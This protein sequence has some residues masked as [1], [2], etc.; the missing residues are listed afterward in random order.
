MSENNLIAQIKKYKHG[1]KEDLDIE[2][3]SDGYQEDEYRFVLG[4]SQKQMIIDEN[5][6]RPY[7]VFRYYFL[8]SSSLEADQELM[9]ACFNDRWIIKP[10]VKRLT[11]VCDD[12]TYDNQFEDEDFMNKV[13]DTIRTDFTEELDLDYGSQKGT[14]H[15]LS[16]GYS[17]YYLGTQEK[18]KLLEFMRKLGPDSKFEW[19]YDYRDTP[20]EL[21]KHIDARW[22]LGMFDKAYDTIELIC[23][24]KPAPGE[25]NNWFKMIE[26]PIDYLR[27]FI[28][29]MDAEEL[30]KEFRGPV[31]ENLDIEILNNSNINLLTQKLAEQIGECEVDDNVIYQLMQDFEIYTDN[32]N[33]LEVPY[34][35]FAIFEVLPNK[36][37]C[38][39][40]KAETCQDVDNIGKI[41]LEYFAGS[42]ITECDSVRDFI[43]YLDSWY[44]RDWFGAGTDTEEFIDEYGSMLHEELDIDVVEAKPSELVLHGGMCARLNMEGKED[45][46]CWLGMEDETWDSMKEDEWFI[47]ADSPEIDDWYEDG[48]DFPYALVVG[49]R[50]YDA[51]SADACESL[52]DEHKDF[53][54]LE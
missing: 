8:R 20:D 28:L 21:D 16:G 44:G 33:T 29:D 3:A 7:E 6:R 47:E 22:A 4:D 26:L 13:L 40:S 10:G 50:F 15:P 43:E 30:I 51:L 38:W 14:I 32:E 1:I 49:D 23:V 18:L 11:I 31:K 34:G 48:E 27:E 41:P 36:I 35:I 24:E 9:Q 52:L 37:I 42:K 17:A 5:A 53:Y 54:T 45:V 25:S 12:I 46:A 19:Q 2:V 39:N